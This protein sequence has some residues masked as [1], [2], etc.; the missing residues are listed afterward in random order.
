MDFSQDEKPSPGNCSKV[1]P[2]FLMLAVGMG[3]K[4]LDG[5]GGGQRDFYIALDF[6]AETIPLNGSVWQF[7]KNT[8]N[9]LHFPM[10]GISI[11]SGAAFFAFC[12]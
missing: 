8:L 12:Y 10:P 11:T 6:D 4:N 7:I 1:W 5:N 3:V 9:Y 2:E